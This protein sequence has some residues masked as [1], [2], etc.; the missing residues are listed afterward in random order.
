MVCDPFRGTPFVSVRMFLAIS[1]LSRSAA[2]QC[3]FGQTSRPLFSKE[4][5]GSPHIADA[6][7][8]VTSPYGAG[9]VSTLQMTRSSSGKRRAERS[10]R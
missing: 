8:T 3:L 9:S 10:A 1:H 4:N 6:T 7:R 5:R 2:S